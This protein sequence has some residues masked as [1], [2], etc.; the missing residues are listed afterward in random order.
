MGSTFPMPLYEV[1]IEEA[2]DTTV[3]ESSGCLPEEAMNAL[4]TLP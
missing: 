2:M 1:K 3:L 4:A